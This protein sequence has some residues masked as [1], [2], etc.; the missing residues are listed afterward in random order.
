MRRGEA[1]GPNLRRVRIQRGIPLETIARV[2]RVPVALWESLEDNDLYGWPTG[3]YARAYVREYARL[4]GVDPD[5]TVN[6]FCRL[7]PQGDR[8]RRAIL[9]NHPAAAGHVVA[10]TDEVPASGDRRL[11]PED[12]ALA[13]VPR[14]RATVGTRFRHLAAMLRGWLGARS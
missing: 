6:E 5:E 4:I 14:S 3:V 10:V 9:L 11:P 2:T 1:F 13:R 12:D 8:R 7:F